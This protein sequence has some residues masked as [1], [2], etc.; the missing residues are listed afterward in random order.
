MVIIDLSPFS[1]GH[2]NPAVTLG[3]T[4]SG[5]CKP[6]LAVFYVISQLIGGILG[7]AICRVRHSTL[8]CIC[9]SGFSGWV[10]GT[11]KHEIHTGAFSGHRFLTYFYGAGWLGWGVVLGLDLV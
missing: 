1:G 10:S 3:V 7:A 6:V 5:G 11:K 8:Q 9:S 2:I 4:L